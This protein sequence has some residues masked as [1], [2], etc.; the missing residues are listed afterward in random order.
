MQCT[1]P[2][3]SNQLDYKS[4]DDIVSLESDQALPPGNLANPQGASWDGSPTTAFLEKAALSMLEG[5]LDC[6]RQHHDD[7]LLNPKS[8]FDRNAGVLVLTGKLK[9][10]C[11]CLR[12]FRSTHLGKLQEYVP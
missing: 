11:S 7:N 12:R 2:N 6:Y 9:L 10:S 5:L 4:T 8:Y 1:F 3:L